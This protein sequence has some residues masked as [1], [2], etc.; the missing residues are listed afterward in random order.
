[1]SALA[2]RDPCGLSMLTPVRSLILN[3]AKME[4]V[5]MGSYGA[6]TLNRPNVNDNDNETERMRICNEKWGV[7]RCLR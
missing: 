3:V 5:G 4:K 2:V 1:M 6:V 7:E